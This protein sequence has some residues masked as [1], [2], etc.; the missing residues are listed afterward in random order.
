MKNDSNNRREVPKRFWSFV[1]GGMSGVFLWHNR[2]ALIRVL[3]ASWV[4]TEQLSK[5]ALQH[6]RR[7]ATRFSEDLQDITAEARSKM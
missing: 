3:G 7:A 2:S 1:I 5:K 4:E 6:M